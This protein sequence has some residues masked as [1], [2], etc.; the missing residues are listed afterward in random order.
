MPS[1]Q[2]ALTTVL[3]SRAQLVGSSGLLALLALITAISQMSKPQS[4]F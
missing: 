3:L 1:I 2:G 4:L